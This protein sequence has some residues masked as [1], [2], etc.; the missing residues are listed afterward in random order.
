MIKIPSNGIRYWVQTFTSVSSFLCYCWGS[1]GTGKGLWRGV[2]E[3]MVAKTCLKAMT[4][5]G[6][7]M[8]WERDEHRIK[9]IN[10]FQLFYDIFLH[11]FRVFPD[12]FVICFQHIYHISKV[13]FREELTGQSLLAGTASSRLPGELVFW[14]PDIRKIW[15]PRLCI[16]C[17]IP[18]LDVYNVE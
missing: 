14:G 16:V 2:G 5:V 7:S 1:T 10:L 18:F 4:Q 3:E 9:K 8:S 12:F 11:F 15:P 13:H 6:C 17:F